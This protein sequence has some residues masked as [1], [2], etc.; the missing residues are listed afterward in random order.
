M[1]LVRPFMVNL[2]PAS[3]KR[4]LTGSM[5]INSS[6][7]FTSN[8]ASEKGGA[9]FVSASDTNIV[10][11]GEFND[12]EAEND[13]AIYFDSGVV[14]QLQGARIS[15]SKECDYLVFVNGASIQIQGSMFG[16]DEKS[17]ATSLLY[18][19]SNSRVTIGGSENIFV[20]GACHAITAI[21]ENIT[22][23]I[24]NTK[25]YS[26]ANNGVNIENVSNSTIEIGNGCEIYSNNIGIYYNSLTDTDYDDGKYLTVQNCTV[27]DNS[28]NI[29]VENGNV[30]ILGSSL[31]KTENSFID[32]N[33]DN[34]ESIA[35]YISNDAKITSH[36]KTYGY[37]ENIVIIDA[38]KDS[39]EKIYI[40]FDD[41]LI[42][43]GKVV[44]RVYVAK[45]LTGYIARAEKF[46]A[47]PE[48]DVIFAS[49]R[50]SNI[51]A[52]RALVRN[53][54]NGKKY[55][56]LQDAI[57]SVEVISEDNKDEITTL[58]I[59][60]NFSLTLEDDGNG[61]M[62]EMGNYY[63][64]TKFYFDDKYEDVYFEVKNRRIN[65]I[66]NI[67]PD[68]PS[69]SY[70][71]YMDENSYGK[72]TLF[73]V[74]SDKETDES[75]LS[76]GDYD[77]IDEYLREHGY[78]DIRNKKPGI[79][80]DCHADSS[81]PQDMFK[82]LGKSVLMICDGVKVSDASGYR[83]G[84]YSEG[85][86]TISGGV[87][88]SNIASSADA[89]SGFVF[90]TN[91]TAEISGKFENM[92]RI[93]LKI[94]GGEATLG[95]AS[96][97]ELEITESNSNSSHCSI[98]VLENAK[99]NIN[100]V[101]LTG[102]KNSYDSY[103]IFANE[104][105][106][107]I[108]SL[109]ISDY[110]YGIYAIENANVNAGNSLKSLSIED[111]NYG[112]YLDNSKFKVQFSDSAKTPISIKNCTNGIYAKNPLSEIEVN[113]TQKDEFIL[114][115]PV[116]IKVEKEANITLTANSK[117][118][119]CTDTAILLSGAGSSQINLL[120]I[121][122]CNKA[123]DV[124]N[125]ISEI[126]I[127]G[128]NISGCVSP[129]SIENS[130]VNISS[131][132]STDTK[133]VLENNGSE[134]APINHAIKIS[135]NSTVFIFGTVVKNNICSENIISIKGGSK[136]E[137]NSCSITD[138]T[139]KKLSST[140]V[141]SIYIAGDSRLDLDGDNNFNN[142]TSG[143][144]RTEIYL[145]AGANAD[146][147]V[148]YLKSGSNLSSTD[149]ILLAGEL[150]KIN[151]EGVLGANT[152]TIHIALNS[153][154][155]K[156]KKVAVRYDKDPNG[157]TVENGKSIFLVD[158]ETDMTLEVDPN[159]KLDLILKWQIVLEYKLEG[160]SYKIINRYTDIYKA[161]TTTLNYPEYDSVLVLNMKVLDTADR[162]LALNDQIIISNNKNITLTANADCKIFFTKEGKQDLATNLIYIMDGSTFKLGTPDDSS[163]F[164]EVIFK[165]IEFTT[166]AT[167]NFDVTVTVL[168][169]A[170][171]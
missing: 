163:K 118:K 52:T 2:S 138:N 14:A 162:W 142:T 85:T 148:L 35:I 140:P 126:T 17:Q 149:Y 133:T 158:V 41:S 167:F 5:N 66:S 103:G 94:A 171:A 56:S 58:M 131:Y 156:P 100:N 169:V 91:G 97:K 102:T 83:Y 59:I 44:G 82:V 130:K 19:S 77:L 84:V 107:N 108:V 135:N 27:R 15:S 143:A 159:S 65:I 119:N 114:A 55:G 146:K 60:D 80:F 33:K 45:Y 95:G 73:V 160:T 20:N 98:Y 161:F 154:S 32:Y 170:E 61:N 30:S 155:Q 29:F 57:N 152:D 132:V 87:E 75:Y 151:V 1:D 7:R 104:G 21:G 8:T 31:V 46:T 18:V 125:S 110:K 111:C 113:L 25:I 79:S 106:A 51:F 9:I 86:L 53:L 93:S 89:N 28:T 49:D 145:G 128:V 120:E 42:V 72:G 124:V 24:K 127:A 115:C 168:N 22:L 10:I 122:G 74:H 36:V 40:D 16:G 62:V 70:S 12:N 38:Y 43:N 88:F 64:T 147:V 37:S 136:V 50:N 26:N 69:E 3:S 121:T 112:V 39:S 4:C 116:G 157:S 67:N 54:S 134:G 109:T 139:I 165:T 92:S 105:T 166:N 96:G 76:I 81:I 47:D 123:I 68:D 23:T 129:I 137:I 6:S 13:S 141:Y 71:F 63:D 164:A 101:I 99:A 90:V 11:G 78:D 34:H 48:L 144:S 150:S 117:I 153:S